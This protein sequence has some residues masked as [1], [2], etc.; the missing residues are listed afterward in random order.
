MSMSYHCILFN[1]KYNIL[2]FTTD[3]ALSSNILQ[4]NIVCKIKSNTTSP[5]SKDIL[6]SCYTLVFQ[7]GN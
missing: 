1:K 4:R 7:P 6:P 3:H 2:E 5:K